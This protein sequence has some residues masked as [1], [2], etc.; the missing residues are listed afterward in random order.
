M[1]AT[2]LLLIIEKPSNPYFINEKVENVLSVYTLEGYRHQEVA[3]RL[4]QE[5]F[6]LKKDEYILFC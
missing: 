3:T 6:I 5:V 1:V 2:A 4:M